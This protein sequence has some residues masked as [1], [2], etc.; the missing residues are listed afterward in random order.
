MK[1]SV[2]ILISVFSAIH[3]LAL[4]LTVNQLNGNTVDLMLELIFQLRKFTLNH[5]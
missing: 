1:S 5:I 3:A 4:P 2:L